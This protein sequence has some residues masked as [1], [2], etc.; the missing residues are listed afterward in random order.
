[1]PSP[2][3]HIVDSDGPQIGLSLVSNASHRLLV[4]AEPPEAFASMSNSH[5]AKTPSGSTWPPPVQKKPILK[6]LQVFGL[7]QLASDVQAGLPLEQSLWTSRLSAV[8]GH[9]AL[10]Y[11]P[12]SVQS[13][14]PAVTC[15]ESNVTSIEKLPAELPFWA[16]EKSMLTVPPATPLPE[17]TSIA[18]SV[19]PAWTPAAVSMISTREDARQSNVRVG[20]PCVN[21]CCFIDT[22]HLPGFGQ[23]T[24][25]QTVSTQS[26]PRYTLTD[27]F[28][29]KAS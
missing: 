17:P 11:V 12:L 14:E 2:Q 15:D 18:G 26:R 20:E 28:W 24:V 5:V 10:A 9:A 16:K 6:R 25:E 8:L 21:T 22:H 23:Y 19:T 1:M 13:P 3:I 29:S 7:V 27:T 4:S